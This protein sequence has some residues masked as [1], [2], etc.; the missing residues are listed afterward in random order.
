[1]CVCVGGGEAW[2]HVNKSNQMEG[3]KKHGLESV[4]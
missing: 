2:E 3:K 1:M 4:R